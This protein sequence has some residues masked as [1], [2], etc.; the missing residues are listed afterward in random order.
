MSHFYN[1]SET[2]KCAGEG[3]GGGGG[4]G[5]CEE[6]RVRSAEEG[7]MRSEGRGGK[8]RFLTDFPILVDL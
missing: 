6:E 1:G 7:G 2:T 5:E 3:R 8:A 4:G